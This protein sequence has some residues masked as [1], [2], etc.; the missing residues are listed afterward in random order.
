MNYEL[1]RTFVAHFLLYNG[2]RRLFIME[3]KKSSK[4]DLDGKRTQGF[5]LGV[6][7]VLSVLFVAMEYDW[8]ASSDR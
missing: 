2:K 1:F 8:E 4:A 6:I 7:L 3:I 5:F